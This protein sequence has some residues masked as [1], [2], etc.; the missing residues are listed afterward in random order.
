MEPSHLPPR[1]S[2]PLVAL[3]IAVCGLVFMPIVYYGCQGETDRWQA[4]RIMEQYLDGD[5]TAA[6]ALL[7]Q[8]VAENPYDLRLRLTLAEWLLDEQQAEAA[9]ELVEPLYREEPGRAGAVTRDL[10]QNALIAVGRIDEALEIYK[11]AH[12]DITARG[13]GELITH[14]NALAYFRALADTEIDQALADIQFVTSELEKQWNQSI[15]LQ[16]AL[17]RQSAFCTARV[18]L[19]YCEHFKDG[20]KLGDHNQVVATAMRHLDRQIKRLSGVYF[21]MLDLTKRATAELMAESFPPDSS[22][23][24]KLRGMR[25]RVDDAARELAVFLTLRSLMQQKHGHRERSYR[26]R[27]LVEQLGF[28]PEVLAGQFPS[29][30]QCSRHLQFLAVILDTRGVVYFQNDQFAEALKDLDAAVAAQ[31][32]LWIAGAQLPMANLELTTDPRQ[33]REYFERQPQ[34]VLAVLLYHRSWVY[35]ALNQGE[36]AN[37]DVAQI[38]QLGYAPGKALF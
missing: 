7:K 20:G 38:R 19:Y 23:Q 35:R 13:Y 28:D 29:V 18:Y 1:K 14:K 4:A 5:R 16:L 17:R 37:R 34:K 31:E 21:D 25:M 8:L 6:I 12:R 2:W 26:D 30:D 3:L 24:P 36:L 9:L 10:Y 33:R 27:L 15:P 22:A 32:A 11:Q